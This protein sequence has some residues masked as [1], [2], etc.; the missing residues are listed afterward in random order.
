MVSSVCS[1][2]GA[3]ENH[4]GLLGQQESTGCRYSVSVR[5]LDDSELWEGKKKRW[6]ED[7]TQELGVTIAYSIYSHL[8]LYIDKH[9][10]TQK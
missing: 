10:S 5:S 2:S 7:R 6:F 4:T 9:P 8:Y 1:S 3:E